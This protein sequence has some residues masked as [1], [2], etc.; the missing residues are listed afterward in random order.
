MVAGGDRVRAGLHHGPVSRVHAVRHRRHCCGLPRASVWSSCHVGVAQVGT[1]PSEAGFHP[2]WTMKH[3]RVGSEVAVVGGTA[4][5]V[6]TPVLML[7]TAAATPMA[8]T[9][10]AARTV[11]ARV[12]VRVE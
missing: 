4:T 5:V 9:V 12:W 7:A 11:L 10:V 6:V 8:T 1:G 2:G 3:G